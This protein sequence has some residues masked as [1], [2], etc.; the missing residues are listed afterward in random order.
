M[1]SKRDEH[2]TSQESDPKELYK[3][4]DV[5]KLDL[6]SSDDLRN[7]KLD[8]YH[9]KR[10][11][12]EI[13]RDGTVSYTTHCESELRDDSMDT[14]DAANVIRCGKIEM[15]PELHKSGSWRYRVETQRMAVVIEIHAKM[16]LRV[17]TA[18]RKKKP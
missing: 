10:I 4:E 7:K 8:R 17:V 2:A 13:L 15:E 3:K 11:A 12:Q 16:R 9:A 6:T 5:T 18:W 14:V 1:S